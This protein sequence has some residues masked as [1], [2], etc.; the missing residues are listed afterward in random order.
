MQKKVELESGDVPEGS[1]MVMISSNELKR[2]YEMIIVY[3][4]RI[5]E[6][7]NELQRYKAQFEIK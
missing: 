6:Y 7:K 1:E 5:Q 4:K 2:L 3:E